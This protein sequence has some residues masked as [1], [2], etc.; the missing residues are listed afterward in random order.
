MAPRGRDSLISTCQ[1]EEVQF[2]NMVNATSCE[3]QLTHVF[4][5]GTHLASVTVYLFRCKGVLL[6][7]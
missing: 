7:T 5:R 4:K 2:L 6:Q 3:L 1:K